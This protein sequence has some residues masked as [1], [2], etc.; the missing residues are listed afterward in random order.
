MS[1]KSTETLGDTIFGDSKSDGPTN[2]YSKDDDKLE[3]EKFRPL[4][5]INIDNANKGENKLSLTISGKGLELIPP[6]PSENESKKVTLTF[7]SEETIY[8]PMF[9]VETNPDK[10]STGRQP[11]ERSPPPPPPTAIISEATRKPLHYDEETGMIIAD[12]SLSKSTINNTVI[13]AL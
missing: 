4:I 3:K 1:Q 12:V 13:R 8:R 9:N 7:T 2:G 11:T 10:A 5:D 6:K